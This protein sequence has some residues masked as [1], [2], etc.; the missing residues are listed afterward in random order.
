MMDAVSTSETLISFDCMVK[1][2][3]RQL[4]SVGTS[5]LTKQLNTLVIKKVAGPSGHAV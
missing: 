2:P 5:N 4:S 3:R 1:Y